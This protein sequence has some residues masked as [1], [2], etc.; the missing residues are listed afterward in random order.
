MHDKN[1]T[2]LEV[3]DVVTDNGSRLWRVVK[4]DATIVKYGRN[5]GVEPIR[6]RAAARYLAMSMIV[7]V[8]Q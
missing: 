4:T 8:E 6:H 3:G 5:V 7:R 1:G 2:P